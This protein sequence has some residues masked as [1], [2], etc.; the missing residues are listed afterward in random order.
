MNNT[1]ENLIN[2]MTNITKSIAENQQA[3]YSAGEEAGKRSVIV[4]GQDESNPQDTIYLTEGLRIESRADGIWIVSGENE[5]RLYNGGNN[6]VEASK[7]RYAT[8]ASSASYDSEGR[9]LKGKVLYEFDDSYAY[10]YI[11]DGVNISY[12]IVDYYSI[13]MPDD[14][15]IGFESNV[16]FTT[17]SYVDDSYV[18][19]DDVYYKGDHTSEGKFTPEADTRYTIKYEYNGE[20]FVGT[21]SGVPII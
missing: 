2:T 11:E 19:E 7:T 12:G 3:V 20:R 10:A 14:Y 1:T 16:Y 18:E 13:N 5:V 4:K 15:D 17:P 9:D 8:E 6:Q 21:V